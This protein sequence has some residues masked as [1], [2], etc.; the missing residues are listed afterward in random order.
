MSWDKIN[1]KRNSGVLWNIIYVLHLMCVFWFLGVMDSQYS[2][3]STSKR[4]SKVYIL[5]NKT[6]KLVNFKIVLENKT[7]LHPNIPNKTPP[8]HVNN[9]T[10]SHT[11]QLL[12]VIRMWRKGAFNG[13]AHHGAEWQTHSVSRPPPE[14]LRRPDNCGRSLSVTTNHLFWGVMHSHLSAGS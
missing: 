7:C 1:A 2:Y 12:F 10:P 4:C 8:Q 5:S 13:I 11:S 9:P 14:Q 6:F 3:I